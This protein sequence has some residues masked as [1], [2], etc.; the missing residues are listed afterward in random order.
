MEL[1]FEIFNYSLSVIMIGIC[2]AWVFLIKSMSD[3]F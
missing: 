2:G 1:F 3:S